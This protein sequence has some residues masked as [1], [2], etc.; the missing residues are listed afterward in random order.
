MSTPCLPLATNMYIDAIILFF[1]TKS[2]QFVQYQ[3]YEVMRIFTTQWDAIEWFQEW[4]LLKRYS[5][6]TRKNYLWVLH[7]FLREI[8]KS[9]SKI[10][11]D[12]VEKYFQ[13][14]IK[15]GMSI[16]HHKQLTWVLKL[17]FFRFLERKDIVW[18]ELYPEKWEYTLPNI[19]SKGEIKKLLDRTKNLKH[20]TILTLIYAG[21]L[22]LSECV[23]LKIEDI[24]SKRMTLKIKQAK[25]K[26]DRYVPLAPKLLELLREYYLKYSPREYVFEWQSSWT[27]S[28]RSIQQIMKQSLKDA[29]ITKQASVHTL[30]H[31]YATHLLEEGV[32]IRII[33]EFLGHSHIRTTQIYTHISEPILSKIK[34]PLESL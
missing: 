27:Y 8:E 11:R 26:K 29:G 13:R 21:W 4:L 6:K 33:Q 30:R 3:L 1:L 19:L 31:S 7:V 9:I 16:S 34:S 14:K 17:F 18:N 23:R 5:V 10:K 22:R 32:D 12:D 28:E 15:W 24:D 2:I 25:W 20:K